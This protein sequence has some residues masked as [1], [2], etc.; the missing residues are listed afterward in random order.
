MYTLP[1]DMLNLALPRMDHHQDSA[2]PYSTLLLVI[3]KKIHRRRL[4]MHCIT[5]QEKFDRMS[6]YY[7]HKCHSN[8]HD[9]CMELKNLP[10]RAQSREIASLKQNHIHWVLLQGR[11][12][13][14]FDMKSRILE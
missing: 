8:H 2:L 10:R 3:R 4:R 5:G 11:Y 7:F 9:C 13:F 6:P 1:I 12:Y 14:V